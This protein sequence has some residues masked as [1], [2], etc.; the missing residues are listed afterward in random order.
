MN[1][2]V[3]VLEKYEING[4]NKLGGTDKATDHSYDTFY[5][6]HFEKYRKES[7]TILEIGVQ[8]GGSS[9]LWYDFL[10][11][12]NIV[13]L[14][15][16][17]Q[18]HPTIWE[19]MNN[20]RYEYINMDAFNMDNVNILNEKYPEGFDIIIEDGP[21]TLESQIFAIKEYPKLLKPNGI[22]VIEDIQNYDYC[23]L[24][25][26]QINDNDYT[27]VE[28]VDLRSNKNRY[29]DILIIVKK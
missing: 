27:S 1:K 16:H 8:Y 17:N 9:L 23:D 12:F 10:P 25:I 29:D 22:L 20:D 2:I 24:I 21:H 5:S 28:V 18:V 4:F 13:M 6:E 26:S 19:K 7:G 15:I 11:N 3:E 14:D